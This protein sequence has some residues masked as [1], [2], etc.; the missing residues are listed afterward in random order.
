MDSS[1]DTRLGELLGRYQRLRAEDPRITI[2]ALRDDAGPLYDELV[3][4]VDCLDLVL[5]DGDAPV[6]AAGAQA[7]QTRSRSRGLAVAGALAAIV[8][9]AVLWPRSE[10]TPSSGSPAAARPY[11]LPADPFDFEGVEAVAR[12]QGI[13]FRALEAVLP[14]PVG[15]ERRDARRVLASEP[16]DEEAIAL[17]RGR[18]ADPLRTKTVGRYIVAERL[19]RSARFRAAFREAE[20]LIG[21]HPGRRVPLALALYSLWGLDLVESNLYEELYARYLEAD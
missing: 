13:T 16:L 14:R 20:G 3:A 9:A 4:L 10:P 18:M 6:A 1:A 7:P 21:D 11:T 8:V 2:A 5:E 12:S 19:Y 17:E 15:K